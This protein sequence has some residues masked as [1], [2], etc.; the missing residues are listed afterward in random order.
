M[1][2]NDSPNSNNR[3]RVEELGS[4]GCPARPPK[5]RD[6]LLLFLASFVA[7]YFELI[8][9][10]YL[11]TE[12]RVFAYLQN[13]P[14]IASFLGIGL[15]MVLARPPKVL[16]RLFPFIAAILF[17]LC[18]YASPLNLTH[19]PFPSADYSVWGGLKDIDLAPLAFVLRYFGIVLGIIAL[20]VAFFVVLGGIVGE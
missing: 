13:L 16:R 15:G 19:L 2:R 4:P 8:I 20:V 6:Y 9:I 14:L 17:L 18:A 3:E 10:R 5:T 7:L 11:S 12:I 1:T